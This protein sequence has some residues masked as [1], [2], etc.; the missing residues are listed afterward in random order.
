MKNIN[1]YRENAVMVDSNWLAT[2]FV[3]NYGYYPEDYGYT[4][5]DELGNRVGY[6]D[7]W[8]EWD[9]DNQCY[10]NNFGM[11]KPEFEKYIRKCRLPS[12]WKPSFHCGDMGYAKY[13]S[14]T[15]QYNT[16]QLLFENC[17]LKIAAIWMNGFR[18]IDF[19]PKTDDYSLIGKVKFDSDTYTRIVGALND[20]KLI[21]Y[22]CMLFKYTMNLYE[23]N[24]ILRFDK[25]FNDASTIQ[26]FGKTRFDSGDKMQF[27][28]LP[29]AIRLSDNVAV[30]CAS[31]ISRLH[32]LSAW[33]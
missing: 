4:D 15:K 3:L 12:T 26:Y 1:C 25:T 16:I 27:S 9:Y 29:L 11:E 18:D 13:G 33:E 6:D 14:P 28:V 5:I 19:Y 31:T 30:N 2:P 20:C 32:I 22:D 8:M 7:Y 17:T 24:L 10:Q 23:D 21:T